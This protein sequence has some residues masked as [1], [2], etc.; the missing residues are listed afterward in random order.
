MKT[1]VPT[2]IKLSDKY[3]LD[4]IQNFIDVGR[5]VITT[6]KLQSTQGDEREDVVMTSDKYSFDGWNNIEK[7]SFDECPMRISYDSDVVGNDARLRG[8]QERT[9]LFFYFTIYR[10][11]DI[12]YSSLLFIFL[13]I[14]K[15]ACI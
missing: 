2:E 14:L 9:F 8:M 12:I 11:T 1:T 10:R 6:P 15:I 3:R 4:G 13:P 5:N 7:D